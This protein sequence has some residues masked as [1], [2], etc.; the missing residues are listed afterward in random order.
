ML[1]LGRFEPWAKEPKTKGKW[2]WEDQIYSVVMLQLAETN[3]SC[4]DA[5]VSFLRSASKTLTM[6]CIYS[7]T[8][9]CIDEKNLHC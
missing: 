5:P 7:K 1:E 6:C 4:V 8:V 9:I 2:D 3:F